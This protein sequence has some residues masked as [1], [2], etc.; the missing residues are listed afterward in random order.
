MLWYHVAKYCLANPDTAVDQAMTIAS[1]EPRLSWTLS[2]AVTG[3][4]GVADGLL[5]I[6]RARRTP[7]S[8]ASAQARE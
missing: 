7:C 5:Q 4:T 8:A 6:A 2:R 3:A 1:T